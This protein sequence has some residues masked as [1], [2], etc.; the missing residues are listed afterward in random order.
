M[1]M[2]KLAY[3]VSNNASAA[4][5]ARYAIASAFAGAMLL[6]AAPASAL[7]RDS[8]YAH[9]F[10]VASKAAYRDGSNGAS[11][12]EQ[13]LRSVGMRELASLFSFEGTASRRSYAAWGFGLM[14]V[15][16]AVEAVGYALV[17]GV[18]LMPW[19]FLSPLFSFRFPRAE[20][21]EMMGYVQNPRDVVRKLTAVS[22]RLLS[23]DS[24]LTRFALVLGSRRRPVL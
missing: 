13:L 17:H 10:A 9:A 22:K 19:H 14:L 2:R 3:G 11:A 18:P 4:Q 1:P 16:Y 15:K 21:S 20:L 6:S 24:L 5:R 7:D 23:P 12:R 8:Q